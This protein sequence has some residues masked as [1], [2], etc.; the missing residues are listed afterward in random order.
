MAAEP[1]SDPW[2]PVPDS[3]QELEEEEQQPE[4]PEAPSEVDILK[5]QLQTMMATITSLAMTIEHLKESIK[6]NNVNENKV[7]NGDEDKVDGGMI[8][9]EGFNKKDMIKPPAYDME[10]GK[11]ITWNELFTTYMMSI[12]PQWEV[13]LKKLQQIETTLTRETIDSIQNELKMT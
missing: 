11:F 4:A 3:D 6:E 10:P 13:I 9:L 8:K 1:V 12:D 2:P 7:K 5:Q